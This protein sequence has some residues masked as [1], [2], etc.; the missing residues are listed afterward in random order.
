MPAGEILEFP[1]QHA[2]RHTFLSRQGVEWWQIDVTY[3]VL[4]SLAAVGVVHDLRPFVLRAERAA[5]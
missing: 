4:R 2:Q 3:L 5:A 1:L